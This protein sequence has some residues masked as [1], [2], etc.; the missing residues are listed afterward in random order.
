MCLGIPMKIVEIVNNF[1]ALAETMGV[2]RSV[3][4][5]MVPEVAAGDYVLVHAGFAMQVIDTE[6]ALDRM[7]YLETILVKLEEEN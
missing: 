6:D 2:R 3:R 1:T 5:D 7:Q 4:I